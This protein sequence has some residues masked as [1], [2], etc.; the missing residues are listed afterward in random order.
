MAKLKFRCVHFRSASESDVTVFLVT[1]FKSRHWFY[2]PVIARLLASGFNVCVYDY[3]ASPLLRAQPHEWVDFN[4]A[5]TNS[6]RENVQAEQLRNPDARFG[7]VG[8]SVGSTLGLHAA[9]HIPEL[10]RMVFVTLYGSSAQL[11]WESKQLKKIKKKFVR[12]NMTMQD[13]FQAFGQ[14]EGTTELERLGR[15]PILLFASMDDQ[16]ISYGNTTLFIRAAVEAN[17]NFSYHVVGVRRHS[18][19]LVH[20][21]KDHARWLPFLQELL[22]G[23]S[24]QARLPRRPIRS[25]QRRVHY[26]KI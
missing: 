1:A 18:L 17:L 14:L 13:A 9:K 5:L 7:I 8:A 19:A 20:V 21:F 2:R 11:V 4:Q 23:V 3:P 22:P 26:V 15:R 6:I 25:Q 12:A 10:E 24:S 16:V